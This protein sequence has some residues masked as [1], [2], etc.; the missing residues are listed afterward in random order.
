[1]YWL[2]LNL[3]S[4]FYGGLFFVVM[5]LM[6]NSYRINRVMGIELDV[7][8]NG[9]TWFSIASYVMLTILSPILLKRLLGRRGANYLSTVLW[10]PYFIGMIA[11]FRDRFPITNAYDDPAPVLGLVL[12]GAMSLYPVYLAAI[13]FMAH[14]LAD[15]GSNHEEVVLAGHQ[16]K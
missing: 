13:Q 15:R 5:E 2:R 3:A 8:M 4:C 9:I 14:E 1:M 12:I 6:L 7:V 16:A 10:V 11:W